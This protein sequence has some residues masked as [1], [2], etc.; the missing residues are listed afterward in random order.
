MKR[1]LAFAL[2]AVLLVG[3]LAACNSDKPPEI[4]QNE[5]TSDNAALASAVIPAGWVRFGALT[6]DDSVIVHGFWYLRSAAKDCV[7]V[8]EQSAVTANVSGLDGTIA[9]ITV[10]GRSIP[11]MVDE[12]GSVR[13]LYAEEV[14]ADEVE[15]EF[16]I[17]L[18]TTLPNLETAASMGTTTTRPGATTTKPATTTLNL[19]TAAP[20]KTTAKPNVTTDIYEVERSKIKASDM[21]PREQQEALKLL[22][23]MMDE[24]GIFYVEHDP[25]QKQFGFNAIYDL[26]SPFI[27]LVY[28]TIRIKFRYGYVYKLGTEGAN[29]GRVLYDSSGNPI[30]ETDANGKPIE[31]DWMI[32][33]WKGRYGLVLLGAEFGIYTKPRTQTAEH[34]YSAVAEEELVMAMDVYQHNFLTKQTKHLFTRG[35]ESNWW[36]TGFVPGSFHEFNKKSEIIAVVNMQFPDTEMMNLFYQGMK[37]AG[38][39]DGAPSPGNPETIT[40]SG[41]SAKFCWQHIDQDGR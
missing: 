18:T 5:F 36:L 8:S 22:S 6:A 35:P 40:T 34:Y 26:A 15:D 3:V 30:Y 14:P 13:F 24:N 38:F 41:A 2:C 4:T 28:G 37:A 32:Q 10:E 25:W 1:I 7:A 20:I 9:S 39:K 12:V 21:T 16:L 27:Q 11:V 19:A 31:K 17:D 29:K 23:Y 33:C